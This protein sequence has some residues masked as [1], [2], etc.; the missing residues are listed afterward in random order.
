MVRRV[1]RPQAFADLFETLTDRKSGGPF[2][3]Y[4]DVMLFCSALGYARHS[5]V[6]FEGTLEQ[7]DF[8]IFQKARKDEAFVYM[9]SLA[10][11]LELSIMTEARSDDRLTIFEEYAN[12]GLSILKNVLGT[13]ISPLQAV[14]RIVQESNEAKASGPP[15]SLKD[16]IDSS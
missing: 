4:K 5:R 2:E 10:E 3:T 16:L 7:I 1:R 13:G 11:T 9:I 8:S 15:A 12:G 14:I 6:S